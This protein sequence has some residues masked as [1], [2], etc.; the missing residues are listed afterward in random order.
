MRDSLKPTE[1]TTSYKDKSLPQLQ[2]MLE[3]SASAIEE[4]A[5]LF[6][7]TNILEQKLAL[8]EERISIMAE[9]MRTQVQTKISYRSE[10]MKSRHI[11]IPLFILTTLFANAEMKCAAGKCGCKYGVRHNKSTCKN[12]NK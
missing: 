8:E 9:F 12:R 1:S 7:Y 4:G 10:I 2:H 3:L 6:N 11:I 5:D